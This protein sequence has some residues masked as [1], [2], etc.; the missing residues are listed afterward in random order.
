MVTHGVRSTTPRPSH[1]T[2][3]AQIPIDTLPG[4]VLRPRTTTVVTRMVEGGQRCS[5][6]PHP[7]PWATEDPVTTPPTTTPTT[8]VTLVTN[9]TWPQGLTGVVRLPPLPWDP[10]WAVGWVR[11]GV[12]VLSCDSTNPESTPP[13]PSS[14]GRRVVVGGQ[15]GRQT[16]RR[17]RDPTHL[18]IIIITS[19]IV[20]SPSFVSIIVIVA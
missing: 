14:W 2:L 10:T 13:L 18:R 6:T 19:L 15:G 7:H 8:E 11:V 3:E 1:D 17:S 12:R 9:T 5:M 16:F 4:V 20:P